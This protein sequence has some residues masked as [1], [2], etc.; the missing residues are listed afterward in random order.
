MKEE[1]IKKSSNF[2]D[3]LSLRLNRENIKFGFL[4]NDRLP[5]LLDGCKIGVVTAEGAVRIQQEYLG[6]Q[7][8]WEVYHRAWQITEEVHEYMEL[9]RNA[10]PLDVAGLNSP[11]KKLADFNGYV[12]GGIETKR[13]VQFTTW[14]WTYEKTGLTLGHYYGNNYL[15]AKEEFAI[16][17]GL[18]RE[19]QIFSSDQLTEIYH[20]A[21]DTLKNEATL[22]YERERAIE[23]IQNQIQ[24]LIPDVEARVIQ[25]MEPDMQPPS[26][27]TM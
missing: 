12:F 21:A 17:T 27:P 25:S 8:A 14:Q 13:G 18:I 20:C 5:I 4:E 16:R 9:M 24:E 10:P 6:V 22:T 26:S 3:E 19:Q 2:F 7:N 1:M 23:G 11:Y 15:D